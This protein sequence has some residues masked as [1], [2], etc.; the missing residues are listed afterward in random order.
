MTAMLLDALVAVLL[1]AMI[2]YAV[3]LNRR[4]QGLRQG[5][6][7][8]R[9]VIADFNAATERARVGMAELHRYSE[10]TGEALGTLTHK[11]EALR[12]DLDFLLERGEPLADR[13][14]DGVRAARGAAAPRNGTDADARGSDAGV[15]NVGKDKGAASAIHEL[16]RILEA[17]R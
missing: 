13:L 4:L 5:K 15:E 11:A 10:T 6:E 3:I 16:R 8:L 9:A 12:D 14:V 1:V 2:V 7:D 17:T